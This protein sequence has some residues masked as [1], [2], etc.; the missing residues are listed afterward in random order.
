MGG[1]RAPGDGDGVAWGRD[2]GYEQEDA[3]GGH[4]R[5]GGHGGDVF[6]GL[7]YADGLRMGDVD[8]LSAGH[9]A[10][11]CRRVDREW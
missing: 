6:G 8:G 4:G 9:G 2:C 1:S 7:G 10:A 11:E 3:D 5:D